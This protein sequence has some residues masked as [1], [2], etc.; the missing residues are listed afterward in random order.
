VRRNDGAVHTL[1]QLAVAQYYRQSADALS[2]HLDG[3][4]VHAGGWT[5]GQRALSSAPRSAGEV[6][7]EV[8]SG[9]RWFC[10]ETDGGS[11]SSVQL[12]VGTGADISTAA[13]AA[14]A[15]IDAVVAAGGSPVPATDG[16]GGLLIF[17]TGLAD[18]RPLAAALAD[19]APEI[20]TTDAAAAD[21]R[22]WLGSS[23]YGSLVPAPYSL[24][25]SADGTGVVLPLTV[26]ELAAVTAGM[27]LDP[28]AGDVSDRLAVHGDLAGSLIGR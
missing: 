14:L 1:D 10:W 6:L 5:T 23:E 27:P 15:I 20:A 4:Q 11:P 18:L 25:D 22:A 13:T 17:V 3:R 24:V 28:D 2:K 26:D 16:E 7:R 9:V 19:R 21:G 12:T 8:E